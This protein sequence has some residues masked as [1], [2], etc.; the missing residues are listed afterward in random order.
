MGQALFVTVVAVLSVETGRASTSS[1]AL[2][3]YLEGGI[4]LIGH[5][6]ARHDTKAQLCPNMCGAYPTCELPAQSS[7]LASER[8]LAIA[9]NGQDPFIALCER[10]SG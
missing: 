5:A 8:P 6:I 7:M 3:K 4:I 10:M 1:G 2:S 9:K